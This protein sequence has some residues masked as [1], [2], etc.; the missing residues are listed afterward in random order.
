MK[1]DCNSVVTNS[2]RIIGNEHVTPQVVDLQTSERKIMNRGALILG[3]ILGG[4]MILSELVT[5]ELQSNFTLQV[6]LV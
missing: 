1:F 2:L 6:S 5:T 3:G 4:P